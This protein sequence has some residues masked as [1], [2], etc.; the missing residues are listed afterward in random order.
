MRKSS[1]SCEQRC[2]L[3]KSTLAIKSQPKKT[4]PFHE[5][6]YLIKYIYFLHF[7]FNMNSLEYCWYY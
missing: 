7:F 2:A 4:I 6:L 1:G 3:K 5:S